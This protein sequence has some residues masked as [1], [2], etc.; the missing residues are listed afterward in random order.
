M[1]ISSGLLL[2]FGKAPAFTF[3]IAFQEVF[4]GVT[5]AIIA[6]S[7][8]STNTATADAVCWRAAT[9]RS[10]TTTNITFQDPHATDYHWI[11]YGR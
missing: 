5:T 10:L 11:V 3:P 7:A 4:G 8:A 2:Q 6:Q 1:G 9:V